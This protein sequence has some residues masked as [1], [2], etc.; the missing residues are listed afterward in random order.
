MRNGH[1]RGMWTY[2]EAHSPRLK[3]GFSLRVSMNSVKRLKLLTNLW[4]TSTTFG[5]S[6]ISKS[7]LSLLSPHTAGLLN[8][9]FSAA[10]SGHT[11]AQDRDL[12]HWRV[13]CLMSCAGAFPPCAFFIQ[14][15][16]SCYSAAPPTAMISLLAFSTARYMFCH[17]NTGSDFLLLKAS[18]FKIVCIYLTSPSLRRP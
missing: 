13:S 3:L 10:A 12:A 5:C 9:K 15:A 8:F 17:S 11:W 6:T 18:Y 16:S 1:S 14:K 2:W 4:D 7:A